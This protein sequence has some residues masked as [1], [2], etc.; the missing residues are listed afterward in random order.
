VCAISVFA[1]MFQLLATAQQTEHDSRLDRLL[2]SDPAKRNGAKSEL[3]GSPDPALL[4]ALLKA[5]PTSQ[6]TTRDDLLEILAH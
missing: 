4:S 1:F 6:G 5:L 2:S 3:L